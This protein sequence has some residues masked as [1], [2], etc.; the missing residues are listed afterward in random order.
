[1]NIYSEAERQA[2]KRVKKEDALKHMEQFLDNYH[3]TLHPQNYIL[4]SVKMKL[5][6]LYGNMPPQ[7]VLR[8]MS[9]K[10]L[11]KKW[12]CCSDGLNVLDVLDKGNIGECKWKSRLQQ[13]LY[14]VN[15]AIGQL[16]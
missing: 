3:Q 6:V 5:G 9:P 11:E 4:L 7:S 8:K 13:E 1:M 16:N 10:D 14:K 2:S 12:K 15:I